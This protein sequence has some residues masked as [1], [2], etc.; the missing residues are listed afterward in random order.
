MNMYNNWYFSEDYGVYVLVYRMGE[1]IVRQPM[2]KEMFDA[3]VEIGY[4]NPAY[5]GL[6]V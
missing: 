5:E 6:Y 2:T 1:Q 3:L 4:F